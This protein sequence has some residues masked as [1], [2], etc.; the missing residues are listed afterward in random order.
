DD[1]IDGDRYM[2]VRLSIRT[3]PADP[4][5]QIGTTDLMEHPYQPGNPMTLQQAVFAGIVNPGN[6]VAV[7][8]I[9]SNPNT[10]DVDTALFSGARAEYT[11]T[12]NAGSITVDHNGGIDG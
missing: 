7:R 10:V 2:N 12:F 4:A 11:I 3:N 9:L 6:I 8:E 1:I 5:T